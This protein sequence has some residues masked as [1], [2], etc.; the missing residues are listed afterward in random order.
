MPVVGICCNHRDDD[1]HI[2]HAVSE[3]YVTA[4]LQGAGVMPILLPAFGD[5]IDPEDLLD[6]LDGVMLT[7]GASNVEP[8]HYDGPPSREGTLHDPHRD[9]V[10]LKLIRAAVEAGAPLFGVCRGIQEI[11]VAFGGTLHQHLHEVPGRFD[12]R[13]LRDR[14]VAE[15][16]EPRHGVT[17]APG[18]LFAE[19]LRTREVDVNS[20]HGQ[21]IDRLG[22][23]LSAEG[24]A[25]DGTV[26]AVTV[27]ESRSFAI[28][29]QWHAEWRVHEFPVHGALFRAFGDA[30]RTYAGEKRRTASKAVPV[31][32]GAPA[33][34][35][36]RRGRGRN[37]TT[38]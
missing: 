1:G 4:A 21:G 15:R 8:H 6:R 37:T 33:P 9:G 17:L 14:P 27:K 28:G 23:R 36:R 30:A 24:L 38:R 10:T 18:G 16:Y 29:V 34:T 20:L 25:E 32:I 5:R 22:D 7:G 26:E 13:S 2:S 35:A 12:H 11:N 3:K 19:L 31:R